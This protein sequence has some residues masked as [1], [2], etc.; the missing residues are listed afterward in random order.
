M[1]I[2]HYVMT[3]TG[4]NIIIEDLYS[5]PNYESIPIIQRPWRRYSSLFYGVVVYLIKIMKK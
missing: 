4:Q 2:E 1:S 5:H 3:Y